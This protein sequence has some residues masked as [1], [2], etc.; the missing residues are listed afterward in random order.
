MRWHAGAR[1]G[2]PGRGAPPGLGPHTEGS[3]AVKEHY[4]SGLEGLCR[5][6]SQISSPDPESRVQEAAIARD[7][8][9]GAD[10]FDKDYNVSRTWRLVPK[11]RTSKFILAWTDEADQRRVKAALATYD[12][13]VYAEHER[14][15][16]ASCVEAM[17]AGD[18]P[19]GRAAPT[20]PAG[21][22]APAAGF[23]GFSAVPDADAESEAPTA[24]RDLLASLPSPVARLR[25]DVV[26]ALVDGFYTERYRP[27]AVNAFQRD[28]DQLLDRVVRLDGFALRKVLARLVA[29]AVFG[30][31]HPL[32][33]SAERLGTVGPDD[34]APLDLEPATCQKVLLTQVFDA[35]LAAVG[36]SLALDAPCALFV[37]RSSDVATYRARLAGL[38]GCSSVATQVAGMEAEVFRIPD[39][40][41][42]VSN[43][44]GVVFF[45]GEAWAFCDLGSTNGTVIEGADGSVLADPLR[46]LSPG[47]RIV[48]GTRR[49]A[50][51]ASDYGAAATLVFSERCR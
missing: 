39:D 32:A 29:A 18:D 19:A 5:S 48:L 25:D 11:R 40:N 15:A 2:T 42:S 33:L 37:G 22:A 14:R 9:H 24:I 34:A 4:Y 26:P 35:R 10:R 36:T 20:A 45:T 46:V 27:A 38:E 21:C 50:G 51:D 6:L 44:H 16:L 13:A 8:F 43:Y 3:A 47:D 31:G 7:I 1:G 28:M 17:V 41:G 30:P 23:A 49:P 12:R